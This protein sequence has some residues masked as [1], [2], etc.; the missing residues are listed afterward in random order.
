LV[1]RQTT[2]AVLSSDSEDDMVH[3]TSVRLGEGGMPR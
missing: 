3:A 1:L 2:N